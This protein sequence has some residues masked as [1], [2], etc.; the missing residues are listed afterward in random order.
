MVTLSYEP[1]AANVREA[2]H[3]VTEHLAAQ[4]ASEP[5]QETAALL[6]GEVAAN[7]VLHA[8]SEFTVVVASS[9]GDLVRVEVCDHDPQMPTCK[10]PQPGEVSGWGMHLVDKLARSWGVESIPGDGK[11]VWFEIDL[12][13]TY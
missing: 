3:F 6:V 7:A 11:C 5:V 10:M 2:R 12:T 1:L 13:A 9:G 4:G 8:A